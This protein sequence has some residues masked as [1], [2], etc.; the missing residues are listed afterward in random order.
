MRL[1]RPL[2]TRGAT[3]STVIL[4]LLMLIVG[5]TALALMSII[6]TSRAAPV[7]LLALSAALGL[8]VGSAIALRA[9]S[10]GRRRAQERGDD[11]VRL[12]APAFDDSYVLI[13]S[14]RLP[15]VPD[16][17]AALLVGPPGVRAVI[18]RRWHGSYRVR[19]LS[20]DQDT[21][22]RAKWVP[23]ITNPSFDARAVVQAVTRWTGTALPEVPIPVAG[24]IAFPRLHSRIVLEEPDLE[25]VTTDNAP[26]FAQLIGRVQRMDAQRVGRFVEAVLEAGEAESRSPSAA[27]TTQNA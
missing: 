4:A 17:L 16:D 8:G 12:L 24:V 23:C 5:C 15:G 6:P 25:V 26:W 18:A 7:A 21:R 3:R 14:P 13:V 11:L 20:W 9:F 19:G 22:T 27:P 1:I 10:A 2:G